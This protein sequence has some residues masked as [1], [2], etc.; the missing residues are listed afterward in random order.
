M[1]PQKQA[2]FQPKQGPF[3]FQVYIYITLKLCFPLQLF[4]GG[5][6]KYT[7]ICGCCYF[8]S[9]FHIGAFKRL[10]TS[11][12]NHGML[13]YMGVSKSNATPK[14][15]I[16]VIGFGTIIFTIHFGGTQIPLFLGLETPS[17]YKLMPSLL[18]TNP[19]SFAQCRDQATTP[20]RISKTQFKEPRDAPGVVRWLL[21]GFFAC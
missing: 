13:H 9:A 17:P 8:C 21:V 3:G 1:T 20:D 5:Q 10:L 2:L 7:Q 16:C 18:E 4:F 19:P 14:S 6:Q 15:S 11:Y 12:K